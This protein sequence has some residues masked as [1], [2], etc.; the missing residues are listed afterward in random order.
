MATG[1]ESL[2]ALVARQRPGWS[3]ER[4]FYS[5]PAIFEQERERLLS[6]HW[7]LAGHVAQLPQ[8]GDFF[9]SRSPA[10]AWH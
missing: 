6:R 9:L 1:D 8:D 5:D 10:N 3:L 7:I 4:A 2:E